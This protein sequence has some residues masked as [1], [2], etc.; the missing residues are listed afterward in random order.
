MSPGSSLANPR[1]PFSLYLASFESF[2]LTRTRS[3]SVSCPR[4]A[5]RLD[6]IELSKT[7]D[8]L[9]QGAPVTL[10]PLLKADTVD[11]RD[12]DALSRYR[13]DTNVI[14]TDNVVAI[15]REGRLPQWIPITVTTRLTVSPLGPEGRIAVHYHKYDNRYAHGRRHQFKPDGPLDCPIVFPSKPTK[16]GCQYSQVFH[17]GM[18]ATLNLKREDPFAGQVAVAPADNDSPR[19]RKFESRSRL[20]QLVLTL[21]SIYPARD[22]GLP[23]TASLIDSPA[24]NWALPPA[25]P[26]LIGENNVA[27]P[28]TSQQANRH[29]VHVPGLHEENG[30]AGMYTGWIPGF[31]P[32][33]GGEHLAYPLPTFTAQPYPSGSASFRKSDSHV[34]ENQARAS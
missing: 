22:S 19:F 10:S 28:G 29:Y 5:S 3:R 7:V 24:L 34:R 23:F 12:S 27:L 6:A 18:N 14:V 9:N 1:A 20:E 31:L 16:D 32:A 21:F 13:V 33:H 4:K 15:L 11:T 8:E 30:T 26:F 2:P 17:P 25:A